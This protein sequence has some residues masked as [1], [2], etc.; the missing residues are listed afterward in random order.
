M[1]FSSSREGRE[2]VDGALRTFVAD[3]LII[4]TG[5]LTS[6]LLAHYLSPA[7][8]GAFMLA[9]TLIV[10]FEWTITSLFSRAVIKLVSEADD[11]RPIGTVVLRLY[12]VAGM[13]SA[14]FICL[15]AGVIGGAFKEPALAG[16]LR[17]FALEIPLFTLTQA[18]RHILLG[19]GKFKQ[20]AV[21]S[22]VY[23]ISKLILVVVLL[24]LGLSISAAILGSIGSSFIALLVSRYYA[25]PSLIQ[26]SS[27]Q[28]RKLWSYAAPLLI[29]S[30]GLR[31]FDKL[32]LYMLKALGGSLRDAGLFG[33]AQNLSLMPGFLAL[34]FSPLLLSTLGRVLREGN[35]LLARTISR[36]ALRVSLW[37]VPFA[38]L[39]AG[40]SVD[41]V[42]AIYGKEFVR[43]A[44]LLSLL[45]FGAVALVFNS[46]GMAILIAAGKLKWTLILSAP[47][48]F[49]AAFGHVLMIPRWG[50]VGAA[51]VTLFT[52]TMAAAAT[53]FAVYRCW[54]VFP[55]LATLCRCVLV[56][57]LA[58]GMAAVWPAAPLP[59]LF[60]LKLIAIGAFI[61]LALLML[62][63]F[64]ADEIGFAHS[65]LGWRTGAGGQAAREV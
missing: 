43:A 20:Q 32:D 33:A 57:A 56:C 62:G 29:L 60:P 46:V 27:F 24:R 26:R 55:P 30:L 21:C 41:I 42:R 52:A 59:F 17:L 50:M 22:G 28:G 53:S 54:R 3:A 39:T 35:Q 34:A 51:G 12:L 31:L 13:G 64:S 44:P 25:R 19:I 61:L 47:L 14:L 1:S 11:W 6:A 2:L 5:I 37:I 23:W 38:G 48:P 40:A 8:Y 45:I 18:H 4:P 16:Y 49:I 7:G 36:D 65:L 63:E 10:W 9:A 15:F 58:F